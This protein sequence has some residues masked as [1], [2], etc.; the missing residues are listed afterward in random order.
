MPIVNGQPSG[1]RHWRCQPPDFPSPERRGVDSPTRCHLYSTV[2][3]GPTL[4][5]HFG[6]SWIADPR[7]KRSLVLKLRTPTP[8]WDLLP[9]V[10][11]DRRSRMN[12]GNR[13]SRFQRVSSYL[14]KRRTPIC[15]GLPLWSL[16]RL[17]P[18]QLFS[19]P[20]VS[21][22]RDPVRRFQVVDSLPLEESFVPPPSP[23]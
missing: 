3:R 13:Y 7:Y 15:D 8:P 6:N 17:T 9:P 20:M 10:P 1:Y 4:S 18:S 5:R 16:A 21:G 11:F 12:S 23:A 22:T 2:P 19:D 14:T